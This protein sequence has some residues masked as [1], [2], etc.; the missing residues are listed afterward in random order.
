MRKNKE[1]EQKIKSYIERLF[2]GVGPSQ[3]LFEL[4][5]ELATNLNER[6][7]D[8][9]SMGK[10]EKEAFQEA[11]SSLGDLSGLVDDMRAIGQDK[12]KQAIYSSMTARI[13]TAGLIIG[14]LLILFGILNTLMLYFMEIPREGTYG[15]MIFVVVGGAIVTY[16][17]L[18]RETEKKY[19]MNKVRALLYAIAIG[20]LLFSLFVGFISG[21]AT[22][23][24]YI[25]ISSFMVFFLGGVGLYL[26]LFFTGS[27]RK[28]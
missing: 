4:K 6:V 18:T 16:S 2:S 28:K 21:F 13:S 9:I 24:I 5:E 27:D 20:L 12:A 11:V 8:Y 25:A 17:A 19:A 7:N 26:F 23:E 22:G 14:I 1:L 10:G 15:A 3:Q